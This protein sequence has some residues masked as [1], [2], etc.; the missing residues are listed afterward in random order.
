MAG[1]GDV[2]LAVVPFGVVAALGLAYLALTRFELFVL[3]CL[4]IR[5]SL[6][7]IGGQGT[8]ITNP[9]SLL[10]LAF[11]AAALLWLAARAYRG[12]RISSTSRSR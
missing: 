10:S 9:S 11:M 8:T 6:D 2:K 3:T 4:F 12:V 5:S 7:A 1:S